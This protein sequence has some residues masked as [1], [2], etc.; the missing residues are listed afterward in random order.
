MIITDEH[1]HEYNVDKI[2]EFCDEELEEGA[3]E[4]WAHNWA[5]AAEWWLLRRCIGD[6]S[7]Y[8]GL[9]WQRGTS[10]TIQEEMPIEA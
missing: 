7:E 2:A 9:L 3:A 8:P 6:P 5:L 4:D 10:I 1:G